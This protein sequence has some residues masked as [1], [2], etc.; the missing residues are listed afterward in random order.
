MP[1]LTVQF[2]AA[3]G[4]QI[5]HSGH[6]NSSAGVAILIQ[7]DLLQHPF[8]K[9][10]GSNTYKGSSLPGRLLSIW[11][12]W[13]RR[14]YILYNVYCPCSSQYETI[15]DQRLNAQ[16]YYI[17]NILHP[18]TENRT[19]ETQ[20]ANSPSQ[21]PGN[22]S[23]IIMGDFNFTED[24]IMDRI[25]STRCDSNASTWSD[26][27]PDMHDIH[28]HLHQGQ[29]QY[30]WYK[31]GGQSASRID[32]AYVDK[33]TIRKIASSRIKLSAPVLS[34]H[35]PIAITIWGPLEHKSVQVRP[36]PR[37][38]T[39]F[40]SS[41]P[42][43]EEFIEYIEQLKQSQ[44]ENDRHII[45]WAETFLRQM[46]EKARELQKRYR[47][48]QYSHLNHIKSALADL[49]HESDC[50]L[51]TIL[52][53]RDDSKREHRRIQQDKRREEATHVG[54]EF[55]AV[56][57]SHTQ[58]INGLR[59][60]NGEIKTGQKAINIAIEHYSSI[61]RCPETTVRAQKTVLSCLDAHVT[62]PPD[63]VEVLTQLDFTAAETLQ[64]IKELPYGKAPGPDAIPGELYKSV[65]DT[66]APV[67]AQIYTAIAKTQKTPKGFLHG[68]ITMIHKGG[69]HTLVANYR[70]ITLL[71]VCYRIYAKI[72]CNRLAPYLDA[73]I[74]QE[75]TAFISGRCITDTVMLNQCLPRLLFQTGAEGFLISCDFQ[76]AYDTINRNFLLQV[77]RRLGLPQP[78]IEMVNTLLSVETT[79]QVKM[80]S[81]IS[82]SMKF[83]AGVR[84][85]CPLAPILYL[86]IGEALLCYLKA[87]IKGIHVGDRK[88][89]ASQHADDT[90]I[91]VQT[92]RDL[93]RAIDLLETFA[94]ASG[95]K[96]NVQKTA[97][98][99]IGRPRETGA[100]IC[101]IQVVKEIKSLGILIKR[102]NG[103]P[104]SNVMKGISDFKKSLERIHRW[105]LSA[106]GRGHA[107]KVYGS[108]RLLYEA[109]H[110]GDLDTSSKDS[111]NRWTAKLVA[112]DLPPD[113]TERRMSIK[114]DLTP[115]R[116][117]DGGFGSLHW[118]EHIAARHVRIGLRA[119]TGNTKIPWVYVIQYLMTILGTH[120]VCY[121]FGTEPNMDLIGGHIGYCLKSLNKLP[122][123]K[124]ID[125]TKAQG[126]WSWYLL[127]NSISR[128]KMPTMEKAYW[129]CLSAG[130]NQQAE[131]LLKARAIEE[132]NNIIQHL[133]YL[134]TPGLDTHLQSSPPLQPI[135]QGYQ[136]FV[137][138]VGWSSEVNTAPAS[139]TVADAARTREIYNLLMDLRQ[140]QDINRSYAYRTT[141]NVQRPDSKLE[142]WI[143]YYNAALDLT[144]QPTTREQ[145]QTIDRTLR[146]LF[147]RA[148]TVRLFNHIKETLWRMMYNGIRSPARLHSGDP[149]HWCN[150]PTPD[151]KH[152]LWEC[153]ETQTFIQTALGSRSQSPIGCH[154]MWLL[155][156][157]H[158]CNTIQPSVWTAVALS[159]LHTVECAF[160]QKISRSN[161]QEWMQTK[162]T[163][164]VQD[165]VERNQYAPWIRDLSP[166]TPFLQY[167]DNTLQT[168]I[169]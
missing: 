53:L 87:N 59:N 19:M 123:P 85:G 95:Q 169:L 8:F 10:C 82:K 113:S 67:L 137:S 94:K 70:P 25:N 75:Q 155:H 158:C 142:R 90:N 33:K 81:M 136:Q 45:V 26:L 61:S 69:D 91:F 38:R 126:W 86:F 101:G 129:S 80:K 103:D 104:V 7:T 128:H 144:A 54:E 78:F 135:S 28:R 164:F 100:S 118:N 106:L 48:Q 154:H 116:H 36:P 121:L 60:R 39:G 96:L 166:T 63:G 21:F 163:G 114:H 146:S 41:Q 16:K 5:H 14:S 125:W 31:E 108:S 139:V 132:E 98:L 141:E 49:E 156:P 11:F 62:L 71:N 68:H 115:G 143:D 148:S 145:I 3:L 109:E 15:G 162:W 65:R 167:K 46:G 44:P 58:I 147:Q 12:I 151:S 72:L 30:T 42:L 165:F 23:T 124:I 138:C 29:K 9:L 105:K 159:A 64:A 130:A 160:N 13:N 131:L 40:K 122:P 47:T 51:S 133:C 77:L 92:E 157:P 84:Q 22:A 37:I 152:I 140:E 168:D 110:T 73:L 66:I 89:T 76:K 150:A 119:V 99:P 88:F 34:D 32:R 6:T 4:W 57:A 134:H 56:N 153:P 79:A 83:E 111:M 107:T 35:V 117:K 17:N 2:L 1:S 120:P 24:P 97:I 55:P 112:Q 74:G 52:K 127:L 18:A 27:F 102:W 161:L 93:H 149:C 50:D 43:Q 20:Y